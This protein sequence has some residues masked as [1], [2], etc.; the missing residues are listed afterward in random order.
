MNAPEIIRPHFGQME[1]VRALAFDWR[2]WH[3]SQKLDGVWTVRDFDGSILTGEKMKGGQFFAF[4]VAIAYGADVRRWPWVERREAMRQIA[5]AAGVDTVPEGHGAEFIEA[6]LRD[7]GEGIVAKPWDSFFGVDWVKVKRF[8][9][10]D[11]RVIEKHPRK[12]SLHLSLD[13]QDAGWCLCL[14]TAV[15]DT[16]QPGDVVEVRTYGRHASGKFREPRFFRIRRDKEA[17]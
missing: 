6:V 12:L 3:V 16:V 11:C 1:L 15:F 4:D 2:G 17:A 8:E 5:R 10:F 14:Q 9:T 7:G 13:G